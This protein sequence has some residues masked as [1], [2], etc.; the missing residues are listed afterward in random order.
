MLPWLWDLSRLRL[1]P[2]AQPPVR[3]RFMLPRASRLPL[4]LTFIT[5]LASWFQQTTARP[6]NKPVQQRAALAPSSDPIV[7]LAR[8]VTSRWVEHASAMWQSTHRIRKWSWSP[9]KPNL[10]MGRR[11]ECTVLLTEA[12]PGTSYPRR[13]E[14]WRH[15]WALPRPVWPSPLCALPSLALPGTGATNPRTQRAARSHSPSC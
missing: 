6:G 3:A 2:A 13:P 8:L 7:T 4:A 5:A 10:G 1:P 9:R 15:L 14:I 12:A 11:K